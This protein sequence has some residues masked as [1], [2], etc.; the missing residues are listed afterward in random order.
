MA[1][2]SKRN[3]VIEKENSL[4]SLFLRWETLLVVLFI[5]VN[6]MNASISKNYLNTANLFTAISTFLV[7]GFI[8]F[9]MAYILVIGDI[10]LSVGSTV[11]LSATLLG[12]S[13]NAG[14]PHMMVCLIFPRALNFV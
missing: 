13:Y 2:Q 11:A 3:I 14:L 8:A 5:I 7:K 10:D 6:V 12:V 1:T 4:K 9:P